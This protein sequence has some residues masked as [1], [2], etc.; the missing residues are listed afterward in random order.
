M[1]VLGAIRQSKTRDHSISPEGQRAAI[2]AW[3]LANDH[4]VTKFTEDLS[5]SGGMSAFKR[6]SLGSWLSEPAKINAWD[7]L[8]TSKLDRACRDARDYLRLRDW[9][10]DHG[11]LYV[12]LAE[13]LDMTTAAGRMFGTVTAAFAEAER[14]RASR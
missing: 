14:E 1:R 8:V 6:P 11:K 3:S 4:Q 5:R 12:S 7:I 13:N 9:C 10:T 2:T